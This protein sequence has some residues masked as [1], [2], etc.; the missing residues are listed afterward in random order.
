MKDSAARM[1]VS[2][3]NILV[4]LCFMVLGGQIVDSVSFAF[5]Y[6]FVAPYSVAHEVNPIINILMNIGG[7]TLVVA[8]KLGVGY[9]IWKSAL[10]LATIK[11]TYATILLWFTLPLAAISGWVG[12]AFNSQ[13]IIKVLGYG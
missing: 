13:S 3:T 5:F 6:L 12:F 10:K 8:V 9:K 1:T 4:F 7:P 2:K 11:G